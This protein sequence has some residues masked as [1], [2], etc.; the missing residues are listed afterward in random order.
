MELT[1]GILQV[2]SRVLGKNGRLLGWKEQ[3]VLSLPGCG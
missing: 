1:L 3:V 2:L